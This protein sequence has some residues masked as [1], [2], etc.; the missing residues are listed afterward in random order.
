M[1]CLCWQ[2]HGKG[3]WPGVMLTCRR[4]FTT[5]RGLVSVAD[6]HPA[7]SAEA[8][9]TARTSAPRC[10]RSAAL[11]PRHLSACAPH[12]GDLRLDAGTH[13]E[14]LT[15]CTAPTRRHS[16]KHVPGYR[17][18]ISRLSRS[19]SSE[20]LVAITPHPG[21][22]CQGHS[23]PNHQDSNNDQ[24]SVQSWQVPRTNHT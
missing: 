17:Q 10:G 15:A 2:M 7:H 22:A 9:C 4:V 18:H 24:A 20:N 16:T 12:Q 19:H 13:L 8:V 6:V 3:P 14:Q 23:Q 11:A 5:S 1:S 21:D